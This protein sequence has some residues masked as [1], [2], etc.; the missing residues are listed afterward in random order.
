MVLAY[1][2]LSLPVFY[3]RINMHWLLLLTGESGECEEK[4]FLAACL[5]TIPNGEASVR[6]LMVCSKFL[7]SLTQ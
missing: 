1:P 5:F 6:F 4:N 7:S 3:G 2:E